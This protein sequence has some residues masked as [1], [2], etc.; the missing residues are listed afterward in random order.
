[1]AGEHGRGALR[2]QVTGR[3]RRPL[4]SLALCSDG[5]LA[6]WGYNGNGQLGNNSTVT[7]PPLWR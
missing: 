6:A 4:Q 5:T 3:V 1:V 7:V 2:K